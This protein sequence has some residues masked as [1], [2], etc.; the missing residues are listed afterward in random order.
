MKVR[1]CIFKAM[2]WLNKEEMEV[3]TVQVK[4][5]LTLSR[6]SDL[7]VPMEQDCQMEADAITLEDIQEG[8]DNLNRRRLR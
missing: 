6:L 7:M 3:D 4:E 2:G 1:E 8:E 5:D